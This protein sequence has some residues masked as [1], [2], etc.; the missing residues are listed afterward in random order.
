MCL[1]FVTSLPKKAT[2]KFHGSE[3]GFL[4]LPRQSGGNFAAS[5]QIMHHLQLMRLMFA[6]DSPQWCH[7]ALSMSNCAIIRQ[8]PDY[9]PEFHSLLNSKKS[10]ELL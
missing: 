3:N 8:N 2:A 5:V 9:L 7:C 4:K 6:S 10:F 1:A